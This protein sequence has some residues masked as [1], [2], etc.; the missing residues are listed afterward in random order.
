MHN[1]PSKSLVCLAVSTLLL[2]FS[3]ELQAADPGLSPG[4]YT[5]R[6]TWTY[7]K[8]YS[9]VGRMRIRKEKDGSIVGVD[10]A[11]KETALI[12]YPSGRWF[13]KRVG[14]PK[15]YP[16]VWRGRWQKKGNT[17]TLN[18][19]SGRY[20]TTSLV[21]TRINAREW[22]MTGVHKVNGK[23]IGVGSGVLKR[24]P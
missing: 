7:T 3:C 20:N 6:E 8:S 11:T 17:L 1:N 10:R 4:Y 5:F 15:V 12:Y 22:R 2:A 14:R 16:A 9:N 23:Q 13:F 18:G 21:L 24:T 19:A